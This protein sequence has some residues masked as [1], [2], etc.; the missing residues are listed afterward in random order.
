MILHH[1][2]LPIEFL[3]S[4]RGQHLLLEGMSNAAHREAILNPPTKTILTE[5]A[6]CQIWP[7]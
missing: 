3:F 1:K 5:M 6:T 7:R 4:V 2:S